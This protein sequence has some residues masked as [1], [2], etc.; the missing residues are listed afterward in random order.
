M[1]WTKNRRQNYSSSTANEDEPISI[2]NPYK[3][4]NQQCLLCKLN[5]TP[6]YKNARLLSQFQ[7]V[8][9]GR[10]YGRHITGLCKTKQA[11][12]ERAIKYSQSCGFMPI[13]HKAPEFFNDPKLY[14]PE[15][16]TRPHP[17]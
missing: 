8:Y 7:S 9:T 13:Y 3:R 14:D 15:K 6:N 16:P 2:K 12:V 5:I 11:Q 1:V 4:E 17:H 10:I